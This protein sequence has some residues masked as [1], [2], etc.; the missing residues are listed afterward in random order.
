MRKRIKWRGWRLTGER[1]AMTCAPQCSIQ[2]KI[3]FTDH[4]SERAAAEW[5]TGWGRGLLVPNERDCRE[6]LWAGQERGSRGKGP[7]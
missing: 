7:F 5:R 2:N 4:H 3:G 6:G 1:M